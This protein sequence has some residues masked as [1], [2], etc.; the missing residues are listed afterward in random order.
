MFQTDQN[1]SSIYYLLFG[2]LIF[3]MLAITCTQK[4]P[5]DPSKA[6]HEKTPMLVDMT[7]SP[8]S[9]A[10]GGKFSLVRV[11][12]LN[13]ESVPLNNTF[14]HFTT[15]TGS[16]TDSA[17]TDSLGYAQAVYR[18]SVNQGTATVTAKYLEKAAQ[19]I[20][21]EVIEKP[22]F[23]LIVQVGKSSILANG[24]DTTNVTILVTRDSLYNP[25]KLSYKTSAGELAYSGDGTQLYLK[26]SPSETD[27][28][29]VITA[30]Y[31]EYTAIDT[32]KFRGIQFELQANPA[33]ILADGQSVSRIMATL[34]ETSSS[35]AVAS[36][37]IFFGTSLGLIDASDLTDSR[38][39]LT[40]DLTSAMTAGTSE[41]TALY[42]NQMV[43]KTSVEFLRKSGA[44]F[45]IQSAKANPEY[46]LANGVNQSAI[47]VKVVDKENKAVPNDSI[48][49]ET[50]RGQ[51][52][53]EWVL[54]NSS[55]EAQAFLTPDP[56]QNDSTANVRVSRGNGL[57]SLPVDVKLLGVNMNISCDPGAIIADGKSE[58]RISVL[59]KQSTNKVAISGAELVLATDNGLIA[60]EGTT[61]Q[62]GRIQTTLTSNTNVGTANVVAGYGLITDTLEVPFLPIGQNPFVISEITT[63]SVRILANGE[64]S[65]EIEVLVSDEDGE[66]ARGDTVRFESTAGTFNPV[67]A[68]TNTD[69]KVFT[70]F[71]PKASENDSLAIITATRGGGFVKQNLEQPVAC[72][73]VTMEMFAVPNA[74]LANGES[75]SRIIVIIKESSSL[76]GVPG[77]Q[78]QF[79]TR[80]GLIAN[81]ATT[82]V[83]GRA[84]VPLTSSLT[85]NITTVT[86]SFGII[87][88]STT[89]SFLAS[90][91]EHLVVTVSPPVIPADGSTAAL[92]TAN[93]TDFSNNPVP[94]GIPVIFSKLSGPDVNF[95][96]QQVT[97]ATGTASTS[98]TA[99]GIGTVV[100]EVT[101]AALSDTVSVEVTE[102]PVNQVILRV[103]KE[104]LRADGIETAKVEA[105]VKDAQGFVLAGK[106]VEFSTTLGSITEN[107]TSD[108][109]GKAVAKF[110]SGEVGI[111][112]VTASVKVTDVEY[113]TA[114]KTIKLTAGTPSTINMEFNPNEMGVKNTGQNQTVNVIAT[115]LDSKNNIVEDSTLVRFTILHGPPGL[116]LSSD[117]AIPTVRGVAK[118]SLSSGTVSG[119]ARI[120][121]EVLKSDGTPFEP[122]IKATSSELI[123]NAGPPYIEDINDF[124]TS[125]LTITASR[126]NIW[127]GMDT[128]RLS[129]LV[130]DRYHNPVD[131]GTSIYLTAS[132]GV[133]TT[134]SFTEKNGLANDTVFAGKP[135]PTVNRYFGFSGSGSDGLLDPNLGTVIALPV[136]PDFEGGLVDNSYDGPGDRIQNNGVARIIAYAEGMTQDTVSAKAWDMLRIVFS[137]EIVEFSENSEDVFAAQG[138]TIAYGGAPKSI[139]IR[140]WDR[141]GNPI[142]SRSKLTATVVPEGVQ[143]GVSWSELVT[144]RGL[145]Q[146]YYPLT[147]SN[148]IN[149]DKPKGGWAQVKISVKSENGDH[150]IWTEPVY[151][152]LPP[153]N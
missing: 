115:V 36:Q 99:L 33:Q 46:V 13:E 97:G 114:S 147:I 61:D 123:I 82:D 65:A 17:L 119:S 37:R 146:V 107:A 104:V 113:I 116:S 108:T 134:R 128:A 127:A 102:G 59:L 32:V 132:G 20:Q 143:A 42:G 9:I 100:L 16:V 27:I 139:I 142:E 6:F 141:N 25:Q 69:G 76:V 75:Q 3:C 57:Q 149:P 110:S 29:A 129:I 133:V 122:E 89:V 126:L 26:S 124:R 80:E 53:P 111:A 98:L 40:V 130:G 44:L 11:R 96:N 87:S 94:S 136:P 93:V 138:D 109:T 23:E 8:K 48:R 105:I 78:V 43:R 38:G 5:T 52:E 15:N 34:K 31:D 39:V 4:T 51:I 118:V 81:T 95:L 90:Q 67:F 22:D 19:S 92:I 117:G 58:T 152:G 121:T 77:V 55:G 68:V 18:S 56:S 41:I 72:I 148:S 66:P 153:T 84:E 140:C 135:L 79:A 7:V 103:D 145:G 85:P 83:S 60:N 10:V 120:E 35:I 64:E 14:I 112:V 21:I 28:L 71:I 106:S 12:L 1:K 30:Q 125:H 49:F 62:T 63:S 150:D 47:S 73:G 2:L 45:E 88:Q 144:D 54:T 74:I 86:A 50:D 91:P 24:T 137:E 131:V 151:I 70:R 101:V